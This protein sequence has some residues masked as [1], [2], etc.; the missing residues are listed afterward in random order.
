MDDDETFGKNGDIHATTLWSESRVVLQSEKYANHWGLPS[1]K[2][3]MG[4]STRNG[5][6]LIAMF[7]DQRLYVGFDL[8]CPEQNTSGDAMGILS[9]C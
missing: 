4:K 1:G 9:G 5:P 2:L 6:F 3:S 8:S 7:N